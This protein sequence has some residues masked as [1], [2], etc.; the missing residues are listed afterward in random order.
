MALTVARVRPTGG[1]RESVVDSAFP[2]VSAA[3]AAMARM[4]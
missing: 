4:V 2:G 3:S 1:L